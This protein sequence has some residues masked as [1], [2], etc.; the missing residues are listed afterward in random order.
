M[1]YHNLL[2]GLS[3]SSSFSAAVATN[4]ETSLNYDIPQ[5]QVAVCLQRLPV[6]TRD[7]TD[8]EKLYSELQEQL[9]FEHS[10]LSDYEVNK[11]KMKGLREK[12]KNDED[13]ESLKKEVATLDSEY[14]V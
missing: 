2:I 6:I 8:L 1:D 7:Q 13:N 11:I 3:K 10:S 5:I 12:L 9:E 4:T 14:Q